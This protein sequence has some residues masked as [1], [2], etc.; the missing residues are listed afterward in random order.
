VG[1]NVF[2]ELIQGGDYTCC[3]TS[4]ECGVT[5]GTH[6]QCQIDWAARS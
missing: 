1:K 6:L 2:R 4:E 5:L 3:L